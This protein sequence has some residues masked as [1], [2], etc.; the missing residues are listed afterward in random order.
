MNKIKL[1]ELIEI[2]SEINSSGE[3]GLSDIR[4]VANTKGFIPTKANVEGRSLLSFSVIRPKCFAFNRRTTRNGERLGLGFNDTKTSFI[5]TED[6]VVFK[7]KEE[8]ANELLP[9]FLYL[10][11]LRDEFDRYVR[12]DSWGS[13]TEFFNWENMCQV[14]ISLPKLEE[15][16]AYVASW[17]GLKEL[18]S[19]NEELIK[20]M[21]SICHDFIVDCKCKYPKVKLGDWIEECDERNNDNALTLDALKGISTTK[22][23]IETKA[24][25]DGVSLTSY[26]IVAPREFAY[27][28]DTSR[29]GEKI[30]LAFN[31]EKKSILISSIYTVFRSKEE[32]TLLPEYLFLFF[33]RAEFDRYA[34]F[35]S[36]GSARETFD[37]SEMCRVAI[38]LPPIEIQR[39]IATVTHSLQEARRIVQDA[40]DL[41]K[42]ICPALVQKAAHSA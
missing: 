31:K 4:G 29:R 32:N 21:E 22:D 1:G 11:F 33:K 3:F 27:V 10:F 6:Y 23:F 20:Q 13:A 17:L 39:S 7:V 16:K 2:S 30:A 26:K 40:K 15:Q 34:R 37:F 36:W 35:N 28:A 18:V 25:M 42:T 12:W 41:I 5:C 8:K 24:N 9:E 19:Q 38:P 14:Q